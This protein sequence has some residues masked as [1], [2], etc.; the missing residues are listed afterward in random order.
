MQPLPDAIITRDITGSIVAHHPRHANY[1]VAKQKARKR[2]P[3]PEYATSSATLWD[4]VCVYLYPW[5]VWTYPGRLRGVLALLG[6]R[7]TRQATQNW[8]KNNRPSVWA[9]REMAAHLEERSRIGLELASE[10][11]AYIQAR[12][13][14][15]SR[16]GWALTKAGRAHRAAAKLPE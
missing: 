1:G 2:H 14:E 10:L 3:Y 9:A 11:R 12:E 16:V 13:S 4:R 8:R 7:V 15:P 6:H 5:T